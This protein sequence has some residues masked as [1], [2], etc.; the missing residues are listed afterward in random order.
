MDRNKLISYSLFYDG[1]YKSIIK[2][3]RSDTYVPDV[4]VENAITIFD[5]IYP[6][7]LL[8]LKYPPLVLYYKGD[9]KLLEEEAISIVG[10]RNACE[11]A[12]MATRG[13]VRANNDKVIISGM[14]KGIDACAHRYAHKTIAILGSGIDYIYPYC[15][16]YLYESISENG[17]I[18]SEYPLKTR[19][20]AY[21]FPFRNR[22][23]CALS[24]KVYIM[25]SRAG[26]GTM[27][28]VNEALELSR[29]IKVL[30]YDIF[31]EYGI[32][33]NQLIYEGAEPVLID[34]I[35]I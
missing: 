3:I 20:F 21:H 10:S 27:T 4:V 29:C 23:I 16:R 11:Y 9:L 26:S 13:L 5:D 32:N 8:E 14:A 24:D 17:L 25:Q 2:G 22:I 1:E 7:K 30:P 12:L 19:P 35:A 6:K 18:L 15:N 33:N 34:E 31:S 28:S